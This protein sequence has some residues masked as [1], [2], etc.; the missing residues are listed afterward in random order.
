MLER[1]SFYVPLFRSETEN[2]LLVKRRFD[3]END[4]LFRELNEGFDSLQSVV[5]EKFKDE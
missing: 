4:E 2:T 1:Y 3:L 5:L